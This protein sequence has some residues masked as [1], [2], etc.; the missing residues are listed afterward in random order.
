MNKKILNV[1]DK[2]RPLLEIIQAEWRWWVAGGMFSLV[3]ASI[4]MSGW[5]NGVWPELSFPY[6]YQGDGLSHSW[7]AQRAIEGWIFENPRSGYPFGSDFRDYPGS[8]SGSLLVLKLLGLLSGKYYIAF[9][10]Y[11]LGGFFVTF[12]S[13]FCVLRSF[14]LFKASALSAALLFTFLPFHFQRLGHLFYTWY[15]V[16]PIFFYFSFLVYYNDSFFGVR[17]WGGLRVLLSIVAVVLLASF[18]V[19]YALFGVLILATSAAAVFFKTKRFANLVL[20]LALIAGVSS[21]VLINI[22]PNV[23]NKKINGA[24]LEVAVRSPGESEIYGLKLMQMLLPRDKHRDEYLASVADFY[25]KTSPLINENHTASLGLIGAAGLIG[26][27]LI[28][29][30]G[31]CERRL[32][33]RL[34]LFA[35]LIFVLFLFGTIGGLGALF[36]YVVSSSIR[37]WNRV[38]VFVA[39]GSIAVFFLI[40]QILLDRYCSLRRAKISYVIAPLLVGVIGLYDQTVSTCSACNAQTKMAFERD[41]EFVAEIEKALPRGSSVY[42]LPYMPFPEVAP[43]NRLHTYDLSVGFLHSKDLHWSYA[44]MKGR[45][46]DLFYRSLAQEPIERQLDVLRRL[47]FAGIYIDR[48]G[49][50]DNGD[51]IIERLTKLLGSAPILRRVDGE[52]VFFRLES[53]GQNLNLNGLSAVEIMKRADYLVDKHGPR[54]TAN[55]SDGIDFTRRT[56]PQFIKDVR[57]VSGPEPWGRWSDGNLADGVKFDFYSPLPTRFTLHMSVR[58]F[59]RNGEQ[60]VLVKVGGQMHRLALRPADSEVRLTIALNSNQVD[61][62]EFIPVQPV[63]PRELGINKDERKLGIGFVSIRF[64]E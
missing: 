25:N 20:P 35:I 24:N 46:G 9:N 44:G 49:F 47:G 38:S 3:L 28:L 34:S 11:F 37:G 21:G 4:L 7:I 41:K 29:F 19:Y 1:F 32:D 31:S 12:A 57:G 14:G 63:S 62:I 10:F 26:A 59:G 50:E 51:L 42:Q 48:R 5:P 56:W 61:S 22:A 16:V 60:E 54:H 30:M 40:L 36:S 6:A 45:Q 8:D 64:E 52:V 53:S 33:S 18:G 13:A 23:V 58:P 55:L 17:R 27:L 15:F 43:L 2:P 39:F